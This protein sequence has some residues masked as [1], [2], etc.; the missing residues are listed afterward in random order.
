MY[1]AAR[2]GTIHPNGTQCQCLI[3][4]IFS[5]KF[6]NVSKLIEKHIRNLKSLAPIYLFLVSVVLLRCSPAT[7]NFMLFKHLEL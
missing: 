3:I 1:K 5:L 4:F 7:G 6:E 2:R